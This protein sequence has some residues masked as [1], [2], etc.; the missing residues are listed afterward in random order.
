MC[1]RFIP[2]YYAKSIYDVKP[3]F[4]K[5]IRV[6]TILVDLDNTLDSFKSLEPSKE[7]YELKNA[8]FNEGIELIIV[9]NN[10]KKRV[11]PYANKLGVR[12]ISSIRK[13]FSKN[14]KKALRELNLSK[15]NVIMIGDQ[16]VTDICAAN[17][18]G[19]RSI[20]TDKIVKEDQITTYFNRL[21]DRPIRKILKR[22]NLLK[23]V[24]GENGTNQGN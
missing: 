13:P 14:I 18:S 16:T 24:G 23:E 3:S 5:S 10:K 8:F 2:T 22:K 1:K 7:A 15:D 17:R 21:F 20:L 19:L 9:S 4:F 12:Y 6:N 11:E